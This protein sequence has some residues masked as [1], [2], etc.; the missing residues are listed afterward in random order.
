LHLEIGL[1]GSGLSYQPGDSLGIMPCN[2]TAYARELL[3]CVGLP[4]EAI[5]AVGGVEVTLLDALV[6]H[7]DITA[8]SRAFL[9]AYA[10]RT[11]N[12]DLH[13]FLGPDRSAELREYVHGRQIIDVLVDFPAQDL[14]AADLV[15]LLRSLQ[16]RLYSIAS[17]LLAHPNEV[18]LTVGVTRY[19]SQGRERQGVCSTYVADR[20][21]PDESLP[22]YV[23]ESDNFRLPASADAPIIMIGPGTGVAPFRAFIEE[24]AATGATGHNW[25]FF[26]DQHMTTDFL[27]Q[28][29]WQRWFKQDVLTRL[30]VAFS[31]D[32]A[33]KIYVQ[34]RMRQHR[35]DL[36]AWLEQG[37][38]VYVCGDAKH[39]AADVHEALLSVV[40]EAGNRSA[41]AA[42]E[43]VDRLHSEHRYHRDVY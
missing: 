42:I 32:Q 23:Q 35:A 18:H 22:I 37:A 1:D 33:E 20:L 26:G 41:D 27:Y 14:S 7:L 29:E 6:R 25:L 2:N 21:A 9:D 34:D 38:H 19:Q 43:Y 40:R 24:R 4:E 28:T 16:P 17:S 30:D 39:M 13:G 3:A 10:E 5:V 15:A 12:S 11:R 8:I 36:F 31:R